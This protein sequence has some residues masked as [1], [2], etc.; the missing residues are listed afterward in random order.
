MFYNNVN[1]K[2]FFKE[3]KKMEKISFIVGGTRNE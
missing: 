2:Y 1:L 3:V